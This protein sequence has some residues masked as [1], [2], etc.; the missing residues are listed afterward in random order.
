MN[1]ENIIII[2]KYANRRLYNSKESKYITLEDISNMLQNG[3]DIIVYDA[4]TNDDLTRS[5]LIQIILE[6]ETSGQ[7]FLP[8]SFL[9]DMITFY[10]DKKHQFI[11]DYWEATMTFFKENHSKMQSGFQQAFE[12]PFSN[13]KKMAD[14]NREIM[15]RTFSMMSFFSKQGESKDNVVISKDEY[16]K[17]KEISKK[18]K[19]RS[20]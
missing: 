18:Y 11:P 4:K 16:D 5:I 8:V 2:K 14:H 17:L 3:D 10:Q 19:A 13:L 9:K 15:E 20:K 6:Q 12:L 1:N 7:H